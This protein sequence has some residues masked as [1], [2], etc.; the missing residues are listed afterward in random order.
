MTPISMIRY[1]H[2]LSELNIYRYYIYYY[3]YMSHEVMSHD[4]ITLM[5][6]TV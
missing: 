3:I 6:Y 4:Y 1:C 5:L 2:K